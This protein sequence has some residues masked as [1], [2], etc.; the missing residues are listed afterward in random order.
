M[1]QALPALVGGMVWLIVAFVIQT[2][3]K[4]KIWKDYPGMPL[5]LSALLALCHA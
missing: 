3:S 2:G 4:N 5:P 1:L